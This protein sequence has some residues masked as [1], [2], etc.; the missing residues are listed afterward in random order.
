M[1]GMVYISVSQTVFTGGSLLLASKNISMDPHIVA[2][3]NM[4]CPDDGY[5]K[6]TLYISELILDS[7][8]YILV[9]YVTTHCIIWP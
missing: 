8:Q 3:V 2:R 9:A 1:S 5:P 7:Y 4:G 6:L